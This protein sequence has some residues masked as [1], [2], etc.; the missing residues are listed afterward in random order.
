MR[1]IIPLVSL[2]GIFY[3]FCVCMLYGHVHVPGHQR[4][5]RGQLCGVSSF[6]LSSYG[7]CKLNQGHQVCMT[8]AFPA[9]NLL[10]DLTLVFSC[11]IKQPLEVAHNS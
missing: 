10:P 9:L 3:L 11:L 8:R 4:D 7:F 1:K 6:L 5:I 2:P